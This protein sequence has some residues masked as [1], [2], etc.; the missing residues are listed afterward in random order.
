RWIF[1][2]LGVFVLVVVVGIAALFLLPADRIAALVEDQF[3]QQ[4]GRIL[5]IGGDVRPGL[6]PEIGVKTGPVTIENAD[7]ASDAPMIEAEGLSV[8]VAWDG[9]LGGDIKVTGVELTRP[10]IRLEQAEDGTGN[11]EMAIEEAG[12]AGAGGDGAAS[13]STEES[14]APAFAL[15]RATVTDGTV[16]FSAAGADPITLSAIN[17]ELT[18]PD[19]DGAADL[20]LSALANGAPLSADLT[21]A[22]VSGL[23]SGDASA[24]SLAAELGGGTIGFDGEAALEPMARGNL[25]ADLPG[26]AGLTRIVGTEATM[27]AGL[28]QNRINLQTAMA[29]AGDTLSLSNTTLALDGNKIS[30]D[31]D[32]GLGGAR[33]KITAALNAGA[34]DLTGLATGETASGGTG[35]QGGGGTSDS[36]GWSKEGIDVSGLGA[37]DANVTLAATSIS[38]PDTELGR[39]KLN[40]A[41]DDRRMVTTIEELVAYDGRF[42]GQMVVNCRGGLSEIDYIAGSAISN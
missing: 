35:G 15:E 4:T 23:L 40:L 6:W 11:W 34:L 13:P 7:W 25:S 31:I 36:S 16:I 14:S 32:L 5:S 26:L 20:T 2:I 3:E 19:F 27:P 17:A 29:F 42:Y 33:P 37:A 24:L 28:G 8:G 9:L 41:L 21:L 22:S 38:L 18:L 30:G 39:T 1:R 12:Q 10:V